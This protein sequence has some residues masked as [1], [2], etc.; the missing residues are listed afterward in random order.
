MWRTITVPSQGAVVGDA[1][2]VLVAQLEL[3][4]LGTNLPQPPMW[5]TATVAV[6]GSTILSQVA[7][8]NDLPI[9]RVVW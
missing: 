1:T 4:V 8:G 9:D 2:A 5:P 6:A 3:L 7:N